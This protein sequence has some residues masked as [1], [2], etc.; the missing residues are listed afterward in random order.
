ELAPTEAARAT[1]SVAAHVLTAS[2]AVHAHVHRLDIPAARTIAEHAAELAGAAA[3]EN[4]DLCHMLAW[5]W[6]LSGD[7]QPALELARECAEQADIGSVLA[8][9]LAAHFIFLE[10]YA[11]ARNR[12]A[13]IIEHARASHAVGNLA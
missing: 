11:P 8:I 7:T 13:L 5:T 2:G 12:L 10:D 9:D 3:R 1:T 6:E 4:L